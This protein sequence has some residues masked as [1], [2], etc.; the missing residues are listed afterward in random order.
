MSPNLIFIGGSP[1]TG[2]TTVCKLL[3][4]KLNSPYIDFGW[5][6]EF[7]LD[8]E[9]KNANEEEEQMSFENLVYILNNYLKNGYK[10][11]IVTDLLEK[12]IAHVHELFKPDEYKIITL[13]VSEDEEL[14]R[15]VLEPTRD[16]GYRNYEEA[17]AWNRREMTRDL[18]P[19]E[20]RIDTKTLSPDAVVEKI[21][22]NKT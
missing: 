13:V 21:I 19:N 8:R 20:T 2:K 18:F 5:L 17:I 16:S 12:R 22:Q 14:K 3:R 6:R 15:R 10:S 9:W 1:G 4:K 11:V 7:H